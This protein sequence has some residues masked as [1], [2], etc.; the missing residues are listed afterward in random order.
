MM[1]KNLTTFL[2]ILIAIIITFLPKTGLYAQM[3]GWGDT[4]MF[5]VQGSNDTLFNHPVLIH[6]NSQDLV[7]AGLLRSD[8]AD[9]RFTLA[10]DG[11]GVLPYY[12]P[13]YQTSDSML[14]WVNL[15]EIFPKTSYT[16]FLNYNN[17]GA[18]DAADF[19]ATFP[20]QLEWSG[21][22]T[23][24]ET[25]FD[26]D[27]I[28]LPSDASL[29]ID[30]IS[31][32]T[33]MVE[34]R[35][36][37]I[38]IEGDII[39]NSAGYK[40]NVVGDGNGPGAGKSPGT[41]GT[42][43]GGAS[44]GGMGGKG[45]GGTPGSPGVT[46]GTAQGLD[47]MPGSSGGCP[48]VYLGGGAIGGSGGGAVLISGVSVKVTGDI[49]CNG[50]RGGSLNSSAGGGSGGGILIGGLYTDV[51][52][53]LSVRGGNGGNATGG[54]YYSGGGGGG[55]RIKIMGNLSLNSSGI[56][57]LTEG[58]GGDGCCAAT[59]P[60]D[61]TPG[62]LY[63]GAGYVSPFPVEIPP[64]L[65]ST[66]GADFYFQISDL[67]VNFF[68]L[69]GISN[70]TW[71]FGD[72]QTSDQNNA[73]HT[74]AQPGVY[75]VCMMIPATCTPA[76]TVCELLIVPGV[77]SNAGCPFVETL[78]I[79]ERRGEDHLNKAVRIQ[80]DTRSW[81]AAG[82]LRT[83]GGD[84]RFYADCEL[85]TPLPYFL[86]GGVNTDQTSVWVQIPGLKKDSSFQ[87][88]LC[89]GD[90][91]STS[92]SDFDAV[93]PD[94]MIINA[95]WTV[96]DTD[97]LLEASWIAIEDGVTVT[98]DSTHI[99]GKLRIRADKL[100]IKGQLT[101]NFAGFEGGLPVSTSGTL[102]SGTDGFGP[103]GGKMEGFAGGGAGYG[104][105]GGHAGDT[106]TSGGQE[107]GTEGGRD[108]DPGSGGGAASN[109][110]LMAGAMGGNGG[111]SFHLEAADVELNGSIQVN[112]E[113]GYGS[114][115]APGGGGSGGG[116]LVHAQRISG[117][118]DLFAR[119][120]SGAVSGVDQGGGGAG[121]RI[122]LFYENVLNFNGTTDVIGGSG[123]K[124]VS[125][126]TVSK[127]DTIPTRFPLVETATHFSPTL[128]L[129]GD[130]LPLCTTDTL[131][132]TLKSD[133]T[134]P[135]G[136][137]QWL[138]NG[139]TDTTGSDL[140][141]RFT[142]MQP[143][144]RISARLVFSEQ[145]LG[146]GWLDTDTFY[147]NVFN[148]LQPAVMVPHGHRGYCEGDSLLL[149]TNVT[150]S[151]SWNNNA[152]D[153]SIFVS[154][155]GEYSFIVTDTNGCTYFSDT[156]QVFSV[157]TPAVPSIFSSTGSFTYCEGESI[158]LFSDAP[159]TLIFTWSDGQNSEQIVPNGPGMY[160]L[161]VSTQEGCM[162]VSDSVTL[163]RLQSPVPAPISSSTG[164]L[165]TCYPDSI[166][167]STSA[168]PP[169]SIQWNTGN[170]GLFIQPPDSGLYWY[171]ATNDQ[172]CSASSDTVRV[173][174]FPIPDAPGIFFADDTLHSDN[175]L[176]TWYHISGS[177]V[178]TGAQLPL[179]SSG[180][181]YAQ[182]IN[183]H[184]CLSAL[185][186]T[187]DTTEDPVEIVDQ[188]GDGANWKVY[189]NPSSDK[190]VWIAVD[191]PD[192]QFRL[193]DA[194]GRVLQQGLVSNS[195]ELRVISSGWYQLFLIRQDGFTRV[196]PLVI[197]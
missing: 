50:G 60:D 36:P 130:S 152:V 153:D 178:G 75:E 104:A 59:P 16:F 15:P 137:V 85:Q 196:Y 39:A 189:P 28:H 181:F 145:C 100:V 57:R 98:L 45:S 124:P 195:Q 95:D 155:P 52:G 173:V 27:Y 88:Y 107:Y 79:K 186:D 17:P 187:V 73:V 131:E 99:T 141:M 19:D 69:A 3:S 71:D 81:V 31:H 68:P 10:C 119:G 184:G 163:T 87:V 84:L 61:G 11:S 126:G 32:P 176:T 77:G 191:E 54:V 44:Y 111:G 5:S 157:P 129:T 63:E 12:I 154:Q 164:S 110:F 105:R 91:A 43:G 92:A 159:D 115:W 112:G 160:T 14:V 24:T 168:T 51:S 149:L 47:I 22:V 175:P 133:T 90:L 4:Q 162:A 134:M 8:L 1:N 109:V 150:Q 140:K 46:Y 166:L 40:G 172:G 97:T 35:A 23:V 33:G 18:S 72:G 180:L 70:A 38:V 25:L 106:N 21:N 136:P 41:T 86:E 194:T 78:V 142:G 114:G 53:E 188:N 144:D 34:F 113:D 118:A 161:R 101:G 139:V 55:G 30:T 138:V 37:L 125:P 170:N 197:R 83:D 102:P 177:E 67:S 165:G 2:K 58:F 193:S 56:R 128:T 94:A 127:H 122:K 167:L 42:G 6:I 146:N 89:H 7:D 143:G 96:P 48:S 174:Y 13:D 49:F 20:N 158:N 132:L 9:I 190:R 169:T 74:F 120:G 80:L 148:P 123:V 183:E 147:V 26:A 29:N 103:G 108:I 116:I 62:T 156:V 182:V 93:F 171:V 179:D 76:D 192:V 151:L 117:S 64:Q 65:S 121:G 185:S 82:K 66:S 135:T